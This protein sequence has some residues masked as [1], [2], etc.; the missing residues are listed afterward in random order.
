MKDDLINMDLHSYS[1]YVRNNNLG[2]LKF[3]EL[4]KYYNNY[5]INNSKLTELK[6]DFYVEQLKSKLEINNSE[7]WEKDENYYINNY[8][9]QLNNFIN[10]LKRPV[11]LLQMQITKINLECEKATKKYEKKLSIVNELKSKIENEIESKAAYESTL[12]LLKL[13]IQNV[14]ET[15]NNNFH[16]NKNNL[17]I[18]EIPSNFSSKKKKIKKCQIENFPDKYSSKTFNS[19]KKKRNPEGYDKI[20]KKLNFVN[21]ELQKDNKALLIACEKMDKKQEILEKVI[22]K[23]DELKKQLDIIL[24]TSELTKRELIKNLSNKLNSFSSPSNNS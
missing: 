16:S 13:E 24:S 7:E 20:L 4:S 11:E 3:N 6:E 12:N 8:Q 19:K 22:Y 17:Q 5:K 2:S 23:R 9:S 21:K 1:A 18:K 10:N 14:E 15:K